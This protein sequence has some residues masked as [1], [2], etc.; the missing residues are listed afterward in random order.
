MGDESTFIVVVAG[1]KPT[2]W[3]QHYTVDAKSEEDA[4]SSVLKLLSNSGIRNIAIDVAVK[5]Q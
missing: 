5:V 3:T 2:V 1:V 4:I